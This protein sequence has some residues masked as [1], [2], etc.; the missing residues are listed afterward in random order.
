MDDF[1]R[2]DLPDGYP[3]YVEMDEGHTEW[4]RDDEVCSD[5]LVKGICKSQ[6]MQ[7]Y[8]LVDDIDCDKFIDGFQTGKSFLMR[9]LRNHIISTSENGV[10]IN[11]ED[12]KIE[13][14]DTTNLSILVHGH[15]QRF[16]T[17]VE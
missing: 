10:M 8:G 14:L 12:I 9:A 2:N 17:V 6:I 15:K 5:L 11:S 1:Y 4:V 13:I 7:E 3:N 16:L